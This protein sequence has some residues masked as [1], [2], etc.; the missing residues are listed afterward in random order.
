MSDVS[1]ETTAK[2][3]VPTPMASKPQRAVGPKLRVVLVIVLTM[4]SLLAANGVYLSSITFVQWWRGV[5]IED[6]F[7]QFMF[8][9]HL[10]L[11]FLFTVPVVVFGIIHWNASRNR[12]NKRAIRIGYALFAIAIVVLI[13]GVLLTRIGNFEFAS[14]AFRRQLIYWAHVV[15][16]LVAVWLYGCI[17]WLDRRL[18]GTLVVELRSPLR[19]V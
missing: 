10:L 9:A 8:L 7:Y 2:P 3:F 16:P 14:G 6:Y 1:N 15:S 17:V 18:N 19:Y 12:R 4:F 13:S 5:V 11:G